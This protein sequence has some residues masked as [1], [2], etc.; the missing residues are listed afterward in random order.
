MNTGGIG[1]LLHICGEELADPLNQGRAPHRAAGEPG[2][3]SREHVGQHPRPDLQCSPSTGG[4]NKHAGRPPR[5]MRCSPLSPPPHPPARRARGSSFGGRS[6]PGH[7]R[8]QRLRRKHSCLHNRS[9]FFKETLT[10]MEALSAAMI[11][12]GVMGLYLSQPSTSQEIS[13]V[14]SELSNSPD[15]GQ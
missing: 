13:Q 15:L 5:R 14:G 8:P 9:C 2:R 11:I 6:R 3:H 10:P 4:Q 1:T 7:R 12:V